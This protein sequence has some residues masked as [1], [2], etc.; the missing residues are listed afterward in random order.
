MTKREREMLV[1]MASIL[2]D[3]SRGFPIELEDTWKLD[4][5]ARELE[6]EGETDGTISTG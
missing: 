6:A 5:I 3:L 1:F 4:S 2:T